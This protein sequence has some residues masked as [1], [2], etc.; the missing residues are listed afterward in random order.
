MLPDHASILGVG[1]GHGDGAAPPETAESGGGLSLAHLLPGSAS[2]GAGAPGSVDIHE[3]DEE[4]LGETLM[5]K[6]NP[7]HE[8]V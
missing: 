6:G 3:G 2:Q 1:E 8:Y 4:Q 7:A 5:C